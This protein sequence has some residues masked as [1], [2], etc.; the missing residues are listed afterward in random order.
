MN[1][2]SVKP[3]FFV[4]DRFLYS[5][6]NEKVVLRGINHMFIWT[7]REGKTIPEIAKTG[8]NCV[9]IVW[10][11]RGRISDLDHIITECITNGMIPIPEIHDTTGNW[12]RLHEAL[13]F[14]TREETLQMIFNHQQYLIINIG[15]E[16]GAEEQDPSEF[17]DVYSLIVTRMRA[18]NI[19]VPIMID[20][21]MWGQSEKN[22][23]EVGP[24]LLQADPEHN[25]L[26]SI[27]MW[28]PSERHDAEKTGYAT[29]EDRVRGTLEK[30]VELKLPLVIGEFAPVAVGG[31]KAI[32]YKFIMSEAERLDIGWLAWSWG[33]GN[34]DSPEMDMTVH[35]SVNTLVSWGKEICLDSPNGIQNT[36]IIPNFIQNKDYNTGSLS[37]GA[38]IIQNG[39]FSSE[40]QLSGWVTDFWGGQAEVK[41]QDGVAKFDIKKGGK[42]S[43]NL[44]F[45][46]HFPLRN[47]VTYV[48]SMR[49]KAD[50]PRT[51]NVNIKKD[52]EEYTPYANG[53]ILDLSTSWQNFSWKFTMKEDTDNDALLIFD[54]GGV[55]ISWML[56]DISL[57]Q[58]RSVAD[59]LNR[60]FQRNV[61]KNSGY[62]N[63][64]NGPWE[65]HLYS[66]K[67]ELL[68]VLDKGKGGEGMR[69]YPKTERSGIMV[70]KDL[71]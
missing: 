43:W 64:P 47:G 58:A 69:Q 9:R 61:Q 36:S 68:E 5:K 34:F 38:N 70:V 71:D 20:A 2:T 54:M 6:D 28:W 53:R 30:S 8:A 59:R 37:T 14:W 1:L 44:Q 21:D 13:E 3:G 50:K 26:F 24:R 18:A 27:H 46:Q 10:N 25:L 57:V 33:P 11:T 49:A 15:N 48:F 16:P 4:Q 55:P 66:T 67:G 60:T 22:L 31:V 17:F 42:E 41:V 35:G 56:S 45:K 7:D 39:N 32:P 63:A 23:L 52:C 12:D 62:F 40:E 65:L 19:R 51:L 29:V